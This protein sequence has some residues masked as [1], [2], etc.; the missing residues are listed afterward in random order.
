MPQYRQDVSQEIHSE[1]F[2]ISANYSGVQSNTALISS[3]GY[4]TSIFLTDLIISNGDTAGYVTIEEDTSD[5]QK[6]LIQRQNLAI[7]GVRA[8]SFS[9]PIQVNPNNDLGLN[10]TTADDFSV[11]VGYYLQKVNGFGYTS[12]GHTGSALSSTIDEFFFT[13]SANAT[14]VG[15]LTLARSNCAGQSSDTNGYTSGGDDGSD[16]AVVDYFSFASSGNA[17]V[18]CDLFL[19]RRYLAGQSSASK[20]YSSGGHGYTR[21]VDAFT[22]ASTEKASY[23]SNLTAGVY[24]AAGQSS[25]VKGYTSGGYTGSYSAVIDS[26]H[27]VNTDWNTTAVGDLTLARLGPTGQSSAEKGYTSGGTAAPI[28]AA[29]DSFSFAS[30]GNATSVGDLTETSLTPAGQSSPTR[31][32]TS[33]GRRATNNAL[34]DSFSFASDGN[35]TSVGELTVARYATA[36]Q[37]S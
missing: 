23:V 7:N 6:I 22:F 11:T 8:S 4:H 17:S 19:A 21:V 18:H 10:S 2:S 33:G 3:P 35:A 31:G 30:D 20:G 26:F 24:G 29:I 28:S 9:D 36:G 15:D 5:N 14:G 27:F 37:Q 12:G 13:S 1:R 25:D 32:Y 34:I 16:S